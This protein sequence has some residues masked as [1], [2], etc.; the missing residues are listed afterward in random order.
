MKKYENNLFKN[1]IKLIA[2][3]DEVGRGALFGPVIAAAVILPSKYLN[4]SIKDSKTLNSQ[5]RNKLYKE[6]TKNAIA[7]SFAMISPH[8]IDKINIKNAS[9][10]AMK[11][12]VENLNVKPQHVL[13]DYEQIDINIKQTSIT[14]GDSLSQTIAAA[15]ILAK[16]YRD[17]HIMD[18]SKTYSKYHL[19]CNK[20]YPTKEH[21]NAILKFGWTDM[22]R[23]T[24][25]PIKKIIKNYN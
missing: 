7:Y 22:H 10:L 25:N 4:T 20:G 1:G 15:S 16:V 12:A 18:L 23:L 9:K 17:L 2:G 13:V 8:T 19:E 5:N 21:C 6:I 24:F 14:K 11:I 3:V